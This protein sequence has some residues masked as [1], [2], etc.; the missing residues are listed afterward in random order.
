MMKAS[1]AQKVFTILERDFAKTSAPI[2]E[3]ARRADN[4][5]RTLVAT[6]LSTRTKDECTAEVCDR[7]FKVVQKPSDFLKFSIAQIER[8]IFPIGFYR[9]KAR[10]LR[11]LPD[12][13]ETRFSGRIPDSLEELMELPGVGRKVANLVL[14]QGFGKPAICVDVHVH[15]ICNRLGLIKTR[16]PLETEKALEKILPKRYW[17]GWNTFLVSFGQRVCAPISPR[18]SICPLA[19]LCDRVGVRQHR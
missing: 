14:A 13:L 2:V 6:I 3:L 4:P 7:L 17:R 8:L 16:T 1:R 18:C 15:R 11:M 12:V 9:T 5:F 19:E 10:H